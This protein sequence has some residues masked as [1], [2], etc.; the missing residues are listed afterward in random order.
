MSSGKDEEVGKA[1]SMEEVWDGLGGGRLGRFG[2]VGVRIWSAWQ[3]VSGLAIPLPFRPPFSP[4][5]DSQGTNSRRTYLPLTVGQLVLAGA[6]TAAVGVCVFKDAELRTNTNR[7]GASP[8]FPVSHSISQLTS[9]PSSP[10]LP[11]PRATHP[12]AIA[13]D[14]VLAACPPPFHKL[15]EAQL[16]PPLVRPARLALRDRPRLLLGRLD[17]L[18]CGHVGQDDARPGRLE[19]LDGSESFYPRV[20]RALTDSPSLGRSR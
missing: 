8:S 1:G 9:T 13:L 20:F 11:R 4:R 16:G 12:I 7:L 15:G 10:R 2:K 5:D 18:G 17:G 6:Y 19:L 14:Q 3:T